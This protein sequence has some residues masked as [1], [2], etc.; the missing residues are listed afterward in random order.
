MLKKRNFNKQANQ[1]KKRLKA[2]PM[3]A[4]NLIL[5]ENKKLQWWTQPM[6]QKIK[7]KIWQKFK[8]NIFFLRVNKIQIRMRLK[9]IIQIQKFPKYLQKG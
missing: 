6:I 4:G 2:F 9:F 3:I 5:G 1:F 7:A 8:T